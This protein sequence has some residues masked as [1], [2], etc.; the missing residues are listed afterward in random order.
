M[1]AGQLRYLVTLQEVTGTTVTAAG[2]PQ[3]VWSDM[4]MARAERVDQTMQEFIRNAGAVD[5][6]AMVFRLRYIDGITTAHRLVF[7]GQPYSIRAVVPIGRRKDLELRCT[8]FEE[9]DG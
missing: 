7:D 4:T 3:Q 2:T 6:T 1:R 8:R 5:E 9:L